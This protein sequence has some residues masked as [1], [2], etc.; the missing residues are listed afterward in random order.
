MRA[1]SRVVTCLLFPLIAMILQV[2]VKRIAKRKH[3]G[4]LRDF[5][6]GFESATTAFVTFAGLAAERALELARAGRGLSNVANL[7]DRQSLQAHDQVL[8]TQ[9]TWAS[10]GMLMITISLLLLMAIVKDKGIKV[11]DC[12][13]EEPTLWMGVILPDCVGFI[14]LASV[15]FYFSN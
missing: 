2:L 10:L 9:V 1:D 7:V 6:V 11:H 15:A 8:Q 12:G 13:H 4:E 5:A 3:V 14:A